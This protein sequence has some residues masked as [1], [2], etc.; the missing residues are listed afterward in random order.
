MRKQSNALIAALFA[1]FAFT[2]S[3]RAQTPADFYRG[4]NVDLYIGY[5]VGG[6]YDL[7]A[8]MLARHLGKH[9]PGNPTVVTK[10]M[11]G[12]G[13]L[14][15]TNWLYRVAPKDGTAFGAIGRGTGFDPVL[16]NKSAQFDGPKFTWIGSANNNSPR[17]PTACSAPKCGWSP[18]I[19]AATRSGLRWSAA[20]CMG[21]AAGRGRA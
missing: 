2:A 14:R 12:A 18:A 13:S 3:A 4:K 5:S 16:G 8:R 21:V 19:R 15:L 10:N 1:S 9:I 6:G 7:Y 17:S 11:E 20:R